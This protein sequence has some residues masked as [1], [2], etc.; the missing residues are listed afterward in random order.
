[1]LAKS[2]ENLSWRLHTNYFI[3]Y[4]WMLAVCRLAW[5]GRKKGVQ[6][7]EKVSSSWL[8]LTGGKGDREKKGERT[9]EGMNYHSNATGCCSS[10]VG[11]RQLAI[12]ITQRHH[13]GFFW[14]SRV[15]FF[16][17]RMMYGFCK[18]LPMDF[19][20]LKQDLKIIRPRLS[21][22]CRGSLCSLTRTECWMV[23]RRQK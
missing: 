11:C 7:F 20:G 17:I 8:F 9:R 5:R 13:P 6:L 3:K 19:K 2:F 15:Q 18:C 1:M 22:P 10:G 12:T 4:W 16:S 21:A 23:T 14:G